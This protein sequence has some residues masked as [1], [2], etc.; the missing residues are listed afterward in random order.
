MEFKKYN[1]LEEEKKISEF[2]EKKDLFKPKPGRTKK[3][4]SMVI[5]PPNVTGSLHMGHALNNSIQDLLVRYHRMN[6]Y[7]TLWQ[8]GTDHAGIATQALVE[9]KLTTEGIDKNKI[10]REK[11][12]EKVWEW[13]EEHGD[14]ILNQLKKLGCSCD[15]SR[16]AFTMDEN[17]SKSVL[18]VFVELHKKG[19]IYKDKKLVNWDTVLKTAISDLEVDQREV[20]SKIYYIQYPIDFTFHGNH[21]DSV[22]SSY[23]RFLKNFFITSL[24]LTNTPVKIQYKSGENPFK[25]RKNI[26]S[27]RQVQKKK[28]LM[29]FVKKK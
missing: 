6:N 9:K 23:E 21:V 3:T 8:P 17:L 13:K 20:N 29:R 7:E 24:K 26:L 2:W 25:D 11:F 14:I 15:W 12:I 4:F 1:H 22:P 16:N 10:G 27:A 28:R 19:L 18:K 5:P